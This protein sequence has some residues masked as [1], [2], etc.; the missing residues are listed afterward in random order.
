[1]KILFVINNYYIRGNGISAS[2]RRTV[3]ALKAIGEDVRILA[4]PNP[5][6]NGPQPDF[7]LKEFKFPF[8]QPIIESSGFS[9]A[10]GDVKVIEE[11][12]RWA[13]VVHLEE[14]FV[15][16][17]KAIRIA[18]KLGKPMTAGSDAHS[19]ERVGW[20]Y[21]ELPDGLTTW[22]EVVAAIMHGEGVPHS[23]S[24]G[25]IRTLRYGIKSIGQ[26]MFRGFKKM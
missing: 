19:P 16:Q 10:D 14:T 25:F 9:Y 18:K 3:A 24:R 20:G 5:D 22:Q 23:K 11:A 12:V 7:P 1:M 13:D 26:W 15:L 6:P 2:A 17:W 21:L 8:F 4:G